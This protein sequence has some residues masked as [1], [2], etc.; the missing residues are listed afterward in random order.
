VR[1]GLALQDVDEALEIDPGFAAAYAL[2]AILLMQQY[3]FLEQ[4]PALAETAL[5]SIEAGRAIDPDLG[6]LHLAEAVY[7]YWGFLE[8][9]RALAAIERA[10]P[11]M[12][13]DILA[14]KIHAWV[15]RRKGDI[16]EAA[17]IM[18]RASELDPRDP[19][20]WAELASTL[21]SLRR[22][23]EADAAL[24]RAMALAPANLTVLSSFADTVLFGKADFARAL[25]I[26]SRIASSDSAPEFREARLTAFFLARDF[27]GALESVDEWPDSML[28]VRV[29]HVTKA[30]LRGRIL[31]NA[32]RDDEAADPLREARATFERLAGEHPEDHRIAISLCQ[33][34]AG[35]RDT[36]AARE[37]CALAKAKLHRDAYRRKEDRFYLAVALALAGANDAALDLVEES[38][39]API[40]PA[41]KVFDLHPAFDGLRDEPRYLELAAR[42]REATE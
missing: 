26:F 36:E 39:T 34:Y 37:E 19:Q 25:D 17:A 18:Q 12:E 30:L 40:G 31:A 29:F 7:H 22:T 41:F 13:N 27:E 35:L 38:M 42:F 24:N 16:A 4:D 11:A 5:A 2:K 15:L 10:M 21:G 9:D 6:E 8:Y 28:D 20:N 33:V 3:W 23:D 14:L 1:I 32:G